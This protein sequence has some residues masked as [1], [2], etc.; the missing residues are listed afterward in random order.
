MPLPTVLGVEAVFNQADF[1][2]IIPAIQSGSYDL[3]MSSFT[4]SKEREKTVDFVTYYSAGIQWAQRPDKPVDPNNACG[5]RVAVQ[6]TTT[7]DIDEVPAKSEACV[8]EGK[9]PD[10]QDQVRQP[11]RRG[12]RAHPRSSRRA[13]R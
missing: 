6:T 12:Q 2:K 1:D 3:G 4:D 13:V 9:P 8:A 10:R 5:L 11:G 7:E